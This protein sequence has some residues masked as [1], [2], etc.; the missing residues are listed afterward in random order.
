[1][2]SFGADARPSLAATFT[3]SANEP[4]VIFY[5][6]W[7]VSRGDMQSNLFSDYGASFDANLAGTGVSFQLAQTSL[8]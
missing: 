4:A 6:V 1:V 8:A 7:R 2:V 5:V 3:K